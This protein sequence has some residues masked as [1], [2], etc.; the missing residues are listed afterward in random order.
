M[1]S[2]AHAWLAGRPCPPS[3]APHVGKRIGMLRG[4]SGN[5]RRGCSGSA[6][7]C[8]RG[9]SGG[10]RECPGGCPGGCGASSSPTPSSG[11]EI[12]W[13]GGPLAATGPQAL[14]SAPRRGRDDRGG[15]CSP[16]HTHGPGWGSVLQCS[17]SSPAPSRG[18][19]GGD[20]HLHP[21]FIAAPAP[22]APSPAAGPASGMRRREEK[23]PA[24]LLPG[25][26]PVEPGPPGTAGSG[27]G[28]HPRLGGRDGRSIL[29]KPG[30]RRCLLG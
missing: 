12:I 26:Q 7:G 22:P 13:P 9:C 17:S 20:A 15:P 28:V 11:A 10:L 16:R 18:A 25:V 1:C 21:P 14:A 24:P 3:P 8:S 30:R 4:C 27:V 2:T 6:W 29:A 23:Q 19:G 5:A